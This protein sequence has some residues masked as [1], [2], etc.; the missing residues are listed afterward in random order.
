MGRGFS[1]KSSVSLF[2]PRKYCA[3]LT[4]KALHHHHCFCWWLHSM[5]KLTNPFFLRTFCFFCLMVT[6]NSMNYL[7]TTQYRKY[8]LSPTSLLAIPSSYLLEII[9]VN[10]LAYTT[11]P[12][13]FYECIAWL[14]RTSMG[15]FSFPKTSNRSF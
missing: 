4:Q 13:H 7:Q 1:D 6:R 15:K 10:S 12:D 9:P 14:L 5:L 11:F 8:S 2:S 3:T